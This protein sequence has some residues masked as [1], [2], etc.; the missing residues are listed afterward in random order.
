MKRKLKG[1]YEYLDYKKKTELFKTIMMFAL[2]FAVFLLGYL[3]THTKANLLTIVAVLGCLPASKSL[4]S[5][6]MNFRIPKCKKET[7]QKIEDH[8]GSLNGYYHLYFTGYSKNF[9]ISHLTVTKNSILAYT[10]NG[11]IDEQEFTNH[12]QN[13]LK[14]E[15]IQDITVKLYKDLG[16]YL[17][18][19]DEINTNFSDFSKRDDLVSLLFTVSL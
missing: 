15:G 2:S 4:V 10:Q 12:I 17:N 5:V 8:I 18:R 9:A 3:S 19:L 16:K 11:N 7:C 13:L 14:K 1:S 6:I